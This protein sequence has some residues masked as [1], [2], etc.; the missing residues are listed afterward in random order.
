MRADIARAQTGA[1]AAIALETNKGLSNTRGTI[2]MARLQDPNVN[3]ATSQFYVNLSDNTG[4]DYVSANSP[5]YAVFG[6][7][8]EGMDVVKKIEQV[9]TAS[10]G[11]NQNVPVDPVTIKSAKVVSE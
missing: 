11:G 2:A 8:V 7:V 4:F 5:G 3:S 1:R 6:K 9:K 10:K